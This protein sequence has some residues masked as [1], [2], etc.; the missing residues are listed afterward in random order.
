MNPRGKCHFIHLFGSQRDV[1]VLRGMF[2]QPYVANYLYNDLYKSNR[3]PKFKAGKVR[4]FVID[5]IQSSHP[6]WGGPSKFRSNIHNSFRFDSVNSSP[7]WAILV[8]S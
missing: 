2:R 8:N 1:P 5:L 4:Y 3:N 6:P 7:P